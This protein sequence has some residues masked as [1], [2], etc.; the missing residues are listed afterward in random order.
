MF[1]CLYS[2]IHADMLIA[3]FPNVA[4]IGAPCCPILGLICCRVLTIP[5]KLL[6]LLGLFFF[7]FS[8]LF[9]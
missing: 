4:R 1:V 5:P 9:S 7:A 2:F 6:S 8:H 3:G